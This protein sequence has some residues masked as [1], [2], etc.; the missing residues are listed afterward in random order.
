MIVGRVFLRLLVIVSAYYQCSG[1]PE[2]VRKRGQMS[3]KTLKKIEKTL[4]RP[5]EVC[6][7]GRKAPE[8][9]RFRTSLLHFGAERHRFTTS[10]WHFGA[11]RVRL[12]T[13]VPFSQKR[14]KFLSIKKGTIVPLSNYL[15]SR[16]S[17]LDGVLTYLLSDF[18]Q[19]L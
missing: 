3:R 10:L 5:V 17:Q 1:A 2:R 7:N 6:Y 16:L 18:F 14:Q 12:A 11:G 13:S 8:R 15:E 4:D 9:P 19:S